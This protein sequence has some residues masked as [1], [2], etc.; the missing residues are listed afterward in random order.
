[1]R[2]VFALVFLLS[3]GEIDSS[4]ET[5]FYQNKYHC[6]F[7]CQ[8]LAKPERHWDAVNCVCRLTWVDN[9]ERVIK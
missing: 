2:M 1:M 5:R 9:S 8:E 3:N 6:I 4:K 7:M